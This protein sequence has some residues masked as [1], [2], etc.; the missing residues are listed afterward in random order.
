[1]HDDIPHAHA[2][3]HGRLPQAQTNGGGIVSCAAF[4]LFCVAGAF[5]YELA[6]CVAIVID[7]I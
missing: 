6:K 2:H 7:H 3:S 4:I 1:M 5:V